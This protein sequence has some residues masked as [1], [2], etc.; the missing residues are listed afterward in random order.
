VALDTDPL[1]VEATRRNAD[2]NGVAESLAVHVG[3]LDA[4]PG[5]RFELVLAN[6]VAA[7]HVELAERYPAHLAPGAHLVA[8]GIIEPRATE[9]TAALEAAGLLVAERRD[10]GEWTTLRLTSA[11][12]S[13]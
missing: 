12:G 11:E 8:S 7:I 1:A 4:I 9:V 6:L 5:E 2:R 13:G 10:D 3:S